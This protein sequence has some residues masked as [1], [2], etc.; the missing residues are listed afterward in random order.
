MNYTDI[1]SLTLV[2]FALWFF[3]RGK[4]SDF[5]VAIFAV[6]SISAQTLLRFYDLAEK[7]TK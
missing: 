2:L 1:Q 3:V 6:L 7:L 5:E 4:G